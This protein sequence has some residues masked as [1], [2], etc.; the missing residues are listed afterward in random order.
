MEAFL[1]FFKGIRWQDVIDIGLN[2]Y[3]LFR[4][5]ILFRKTNVFRILIGVALLWI[6]QQAAAFLGLIV[7]SWVVQAITTVAALIIVVVFRNEIRS[8]LQTKNIR[9]ILWGVSFKQPQTP[10]QMIVESAFDLAKRRIGAIMVIQGKESLSE[11]VQQGIPCNAVIS[12]EMITSIF[13][14]DNPVHDGAMIIDGDQI[15][16]VGVI[17]PLSLRQDLPSYYGTRHR[18]AIGIAEMT[19][20]LV[21]VVSEERGTILA[22]RGNQ[23]QRVLR[24]EELADI[25]SRHGGDEGRHDAAQTRRLRIEAATAA[26]LSFLVITGA[27]YSIT[28]GLETL[29]TIDVPIEYMNRSPAMEIVDTSVSA[30]RLQL[31][32]S[33]T[34]IR[35]VRQDQVRVRID[36]DGAV[37]GKNTYTIT[38]DNISLPPGLFIKG[39]QP[40]TVEVTLDTPGKKML[41]IQADWTGKLP[42]NLRIASVQI[43]PSR[44]LVVGGSRIL[45]KIQ[46]VYTEKISLDTITSSR[47]ISVNLALTPASLKVGPGYREKVMVDIVVKP[48]ETK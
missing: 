3:I 2:S 37:V 20:A 46:T 40:A 28:R 36:L 14:P 1:H 31:S 4:F 7:T 10:V 13:W 30:L 29:T 19:D 34:L 39:Y 15:A 33:D 38:N 18:A 5:Y 44:V 6:F 35:S 45:E 22:I 16:E 11:A 8:V 9:A 21:I 47:S 17:L 32:G 23:I 12:R 48:K 27:W 41:P 42:E 26:F 24:P 43:E 25:L